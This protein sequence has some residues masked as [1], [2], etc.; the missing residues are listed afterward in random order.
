MDI[1]E[2]GDVPILNQAGV[3]TNNQGYALVPYITAYRKNVIDIDTSALPDNTEMELT[4]QT[5]AP[6]RGAL[7]KASFAA[8]VG[9]RAMMELK[10]ADG[11]PVPFGAQA[12]FKD[13]NQLNG[14]VGNDGEIYLS[15]LTESGSF[16]IQYN[17]KQQCQVNYNL[18]DVSNYLGLYKTTATCQ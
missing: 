2:A 17:D 3:V 1:P 10:F 7:V 14:M 13:N 18:T 15:G 9:Y 4:S 16:I 5:V 11:K 6:S 12:I 8:N